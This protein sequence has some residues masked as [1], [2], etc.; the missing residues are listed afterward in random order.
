VRIPWALSKSTKIFTEV[1][2]RMVV[3]VAASERSLRCHGTVSGKALFQMQDIGR[4]KLALIFISMEWVVMH[5]THHVCM[6]SAWPV[7]S[8]HLN[9]WSCRP[10]LYMFYH[11]QLVQ[12]CYSW[13]E[14]FNTIVTQIQLYLIK[15]LKPNWMPNLSLTECQILAVVEFGECMDRIQL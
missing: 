7:S 6:R 13:L 15:L 1:A 4:S 8:K 5:A 14:Y 9:M 10:S 3:C 12:Q 11:H 2:P